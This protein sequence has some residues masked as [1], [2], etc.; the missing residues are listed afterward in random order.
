MSRL[1]HTSSVTE[2]RGVIRAAICFALIA[3]LF[4]ALLPTSHAVCDGSPRLGLP[5]EEDTSL[6]GNRAL[7]A[8]LGR[9][10]FLEP[11]LAEDGVV[12]CSMCHVPEQGFTVNSIPTASGRGGI[13]LRRN[14]PSLL[15]IGLAKSLFRDG[16]VHALEDQIWG[17]LL[18]PEEQWNPTIEDVVSRL[19]ARA[20]YDKA[21]KTAFAGQRVS[22]QLISAA[23]AAYERSL[24]AAGS[25]FD[26]W[27]FGEIDGALSV[28]ARAGFDVFKTSGCSHCHAIERSHANFADDS[29]RNTGI[30]WARMNGQLGSAKTTPDLGC[31]EVTGR[32]ADRYAFRVPTLRNVALTFP[33]M[34]DGSLATLRDVVDF[35]DAGSG[36]D[37]TR[38]MR[39][40]R[41]N[42]GERQ[43]AQLI[44]FLESLTSINAGELAKQARAPVANR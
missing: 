16:R 42:L 27:S 19:K 31:F 2:T 15:N 14:A 22:K 3:A 37:P 7:Q 29:Y 17:P 4:F 34:H 41:L 35:Y 10:L 23:L 43:K 20:N 28:E 32:E 39:L 11:H 1:W 40:R 25:P 9:Q 6:P 5:A 13:I 12:S 33:Y 44:A 18:N 24:V 26:Q 30:E 21:F 38:E 8:E 36:N